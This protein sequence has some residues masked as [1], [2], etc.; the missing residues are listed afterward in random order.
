MAQ[1]DAYTVVGAIYSKKK[2]KNNFEKYSEQTLKNCVLKNDF[3]CWA[4]NLEKIIIILFNLLAALNP[5]NTPKSNC[6]LNIVLQSLT[7]GAN[8]IAFNSQTVV[9]QVPIRAIIST[10]TQIKYKW[11]TR[12]K[13]NK[14]KKKLINFPTNFEQV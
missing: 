2:K 5:I 14:N 4:Y 10:S 9:R 1:L 8:K 3:L 7:N 13:Q 12:N 6:I 11:T